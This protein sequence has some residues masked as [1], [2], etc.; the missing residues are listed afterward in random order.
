MKLLG[1]DIGTTGICGVLY[2]TQTKLVISSITKNNTAFI[3]SDKSFEKIQD[4]AIIMG[5]VNDITA[6]FDNYDAIGFSGQMHGILYL[7]KNGTAVSPLY[8]WQ[9]ARGGEISSNGQTYAER[10]GCF[11]GYGLATDLY[12]EEHGLIP[13]EAETLCT[14][15]DY[16]AMTLC[17]KRRPLVHITNAASLG[18]FD[19]EDNCFTVDN[20]RLPDV[21]ADFTLVGETEKGIPVAVC[22]G[23]NQAGFIG[24]VPDENAVLLNIGTGAQI[25]YLTD[26]P[27][28]HQAEIRPFD[29]KRYLA[30]G[31]SLCGGRAFAMFEKFCREIAAA[32]GAEISSF[33][34]MLDAVLSEE[35]E[36]DLVADCR[37]CGTRKEPQLTGGFQNLTEAN[38]HL[39]DFALAI[40][41]GMV[42]ELFEMYEG[43][44]NPLII[45][46]GN[47]IRK[48]PVIKSI[49]KSY[50][51]TEPKAPCY[52]EEA[53]VG[54]AFTAGVAIGHIASI[55]EAM[56]QIP[57]E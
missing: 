36:T 11:A 24:S 3:K 15:G 9:D 25:S 52:E 35:Y 31:C 55:Y 45:T 34:P 40:P 33:Y 56:K 41:D 43:V 23:D 22:I 49:I 57:L 32:A 26:I 10:L 18:A 42:R 21:T 14:I 30:A 50:F 13:K 38:F 2:D 39:K 5:I 17:K 27:K 47:G 4:P 16:A 7:D 6:S 28:A 19:I 1:I 48:N 51:G 44:K 53:A 37:F 29:G 46:S 12:N 8:I 20:P 54:A